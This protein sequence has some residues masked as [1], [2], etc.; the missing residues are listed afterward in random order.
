MKNYKKYHLLFFFAVLMFGACEDEEGIIN[1]TGYQAEIVSVSMDEMLGEAIVDDHIVRAFVKVTVG[2]S[3]DLTALAPVI[4]TTEGTSVV[5]ASGSA[6]DFTEPVVYTI[7]AANGRTKEWEITA[8][9]YVPPVD[10]PRRTQLASFDDGTN[11][12]G[13]SWLGGAAAIIDNPDATD[14]NNSSKVLQLTKVDAYSYGYNQSL[15]LIGISLEDGKLP[16]FD[17]ANG[18]YFRLLVY[19]PNADG[20]AKITMKLEGITGDPKASVTTSKTNEWQEIFFDFTGTD[21]SQGEL[22]KITWHFDE[23]N[24]DTAR[25]FYWDG[26]EQLDKL[27]EEDITFLADFEDG[28]NDFGVSWLGG[29]A[30]ITDNPDATDPNGSTKVLQLTKVDAY[31]YGYNQSLALIGISIED[32]KLPNFDFANGQVFKVHVYNPNADGNAKI[33]MKLE[34]ITGDP[35][36]TVE[37]TKAN[38][39]EA[40]YFDFSG[41]DVSQGELKKI[42]WHFDEGNGDTAR[43]FY[44]DNL[45]QVKE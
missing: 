17:F 31:S 4:E 34:G 20:N 42:T 3:V 35:K 14:A 33:T 22:K 19:N 8:V 16:D 6:Q 7:T 2:E 38:E 9:N 15:A 40:I 21:I 10:G 45:G 11:D 37:T 41:T 13:V 1:D 39:W 32:G 24:G 23:G 36:A 12:F 29:A 28:T 18:Q 44:W 26:F 5:P 27:P 25:K 30:A 43:K